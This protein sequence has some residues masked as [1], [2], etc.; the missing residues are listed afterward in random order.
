M[1][2]SAWEGDCGDTGLQGSGHSPRAPAAP[3]PCLTLEQKHLPPTLSSPGLPHHEV[4]SIPPCPKPARWGNVAPARQGGEGGRAV[5]PPCCWA[6]CTHR[7]HPPQ[8]GSLPS[9]RQGKLRHKWLDHTAATV[10]LSPSLPPWWGCRHLGLASS[11]NHCPGQSLHPAADSGQ[12]RGAGR[13]GR[14]RKHNIN[15]HSALNLSEG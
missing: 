7:Q 13:G 5:Q 10:I 15:P 3:D 1:A 8:T 9:F 2:F 12:P 14:R 6:L 11:C 4:T